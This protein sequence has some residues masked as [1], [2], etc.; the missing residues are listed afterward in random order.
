MFIPQFRPA[1]GG[2]ERQAEKLALALVA[3]GCS[4]TVLTP[5][6]DRDSPDEETIDGVLVVRF[7]LF[8]LSQLWR[9][10]GVGLLNAPLILLQ[11][12][13]AVYPYMLVADVL[14]AHL[15]SIH[16]LGAVLAA[17]LAGKP[18]LCKAAV[19]DDGSDLGELKRQGAIGKIV[20]WMLVRFVP[21]WIATTHAV[22]LELKRA[23]VRHERITQ[24]PNGVD[25]SF[26]KEIKLRPVRRFLY[27]GRISTNAKRDTDTLIAA[28]EKLALDLPDVELALVGGGDLF[29][30][31]KRRILASASRGRIYLHGFDDP[32]KWLK[33]GDC[34]VLPSVRE[35]LSNALLEAMSSGLACIANDIPPNR[36]VLAD[37]GSG[38]LVPGGRVDCLENVMRKMVTDEEFS[39]IMRLAAMRRV[40]NSYRICSVAEQYMTLYNK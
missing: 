11:I 19:A 37:G 26:A 32:E 21:R 22:A 15:G 20:A 38:V 36:E 18:S 8:D 7:F 23:G 14:H 17:R 1:V 34:F 29:E 12:I 33:W 4:V 31:C 27:L 16:T 5:R 40:R 25:H 35:G 39:N 10:Y 24:I 2:A 28:F 9:F 6:I 3:K 13:R 30:A